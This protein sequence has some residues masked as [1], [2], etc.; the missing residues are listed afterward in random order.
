M[1]L[2]RSK[3][4]RIGQGFPGPQYVKAGT[5]TMEHRVDTGMRTTMAKKP[6]KISSGPCKAIALR[7]GPN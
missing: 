4:D 3:S 7:A 1:A 2:Q 5:N 6:L